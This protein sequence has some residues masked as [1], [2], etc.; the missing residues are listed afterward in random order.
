MAS[1]PDGK[2]PATAAYNGVWLWNVA[3]REPRARLSGKA[4]TD[5]TNGAQDV[6][7]SPRGGLVA[8]TGL[9]GPVQLWKNP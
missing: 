4:D 2:T 8:G 7:F 3:E 5:K 1:S 9:K 6:A